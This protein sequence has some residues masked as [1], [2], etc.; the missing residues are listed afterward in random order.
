MRGIGALILPISLAASVPAAGQ[1]TADAFRG[2]LVKAMASR[3]R[4][5]V[6]R[7]IN[8]Q[9]PTPNSQETRRLGSWGLGVGSVIA[10]VTIG[11]RP[12]G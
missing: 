3:D 8:S 5:A 2:A 6:A 11:L 9:N 4:A 12:R 7:M 1:S 10:G